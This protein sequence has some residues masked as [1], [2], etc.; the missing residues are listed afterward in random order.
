MFHELEFGDKLYYIDPKTPTQISELTVKE[1]RQATVRTHVIVV[2]FKSDR[3]TELIK[4]INDSFEEAPVG[5]IACPRNASDII[6]VSI[7]PSIYATN[8]RWLEKWMGK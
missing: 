8:K 7:P 3:A 1:V 2:Y 6:T 4:K 5:K